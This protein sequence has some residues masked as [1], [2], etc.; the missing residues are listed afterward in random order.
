MSLLVDTH[1]L[2]WWIEGSKRLGLEAKESIQHPRGTLLLSAASVWEIAIKSA[3]GRLKLSR[4]PEEFVPTLLSRG[5]RELPITV[6]HALAAGKLRLHHADPFDRMLI[7]QAQ[8]E[9][10]TIMTVDT[11]FRA[12]D[13]RTIDASA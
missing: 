2:V 9:G 5:F 6:E 3:V 12:Y 7:A 4:K 10:L 8:C 1:V 13:V 11:A